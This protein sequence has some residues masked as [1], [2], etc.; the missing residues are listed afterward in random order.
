MD[1]GC[2]TAPEIDTRALPGLASVPSS[3]NQPAP[4]RP[5]SPTWAQV[6]AFI[7]Q[8]GR[9]ADVQ[10]VRVA[11]V[12]TA[13][14]SRCRSASARAPTPRP[15]RSATAACAGRTPDAAASQAFVQDRALDVVHDGGVV[16]R[17]ADG[18]ASW[19]RSSRPDTRRRRA[20]GGGSS[21]ATSGPCGPRARPPWRS[22]RR[23]CRAAL[24]AQ[25][26]PPFVAVGSRR[27]RDRRVPRL[28]ARSNRAG[29]RGAAP[30]VA[31][32]SP[33]RERSIRAR[34]AGPA[35]ATRSS[36]TGRDARV[37]RGRRR[38]RGAASG[39]SAVRP[40][41][42]VRSLRSNARAPRTTTDRGARRARRRDPM[43]VVAVGAGQE[44]VG[45][46]R[47]RRRAN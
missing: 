21:R 13:A 34:R 2:G 41:A 30:K 20:R 39:E 46:R 18:D 25:R 1:V 35:A 8:R 43:P 33:Q 44:T 15:R 22:R 17:H 31:S 9:A 5:M 23:P 47:S 19:R 36:C 45:D 37:A 40:D 28:R 38:L 42:R 6:S 27:R 11:S 32:C 12:G 10:D 24:A 4:N 16:A 29:A 3:R 26:S 7:D 14:S